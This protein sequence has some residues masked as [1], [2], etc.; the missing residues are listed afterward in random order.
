MTYTPITF[1]ESFPVN[2]SSE[3]G[4]YGKVSIGIRHLGGGVGHGKPVL[5]VLDY[6][7]SDWN[8]AESPSG[9]AAV[10][11]TLLERSGWVEKFD[12]PNTIDLRRRFAFPSRQW[13][14]RPTIELLA[15][16]VVA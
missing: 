2:F 4:P 3:L 11:R 5:L 15:Y 9:H 12:I 1:Q 14:N 6:E 10:I 8:E 13:G 7:D 16:G